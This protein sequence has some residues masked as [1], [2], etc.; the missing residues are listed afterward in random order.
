M[1]DFIQIF[2][3]MR[4]TIAFNWKGLKRFSNVD[5]WTYRL[6]VSAEFCSFMEKRLEG[7]LYWG[8]SL[9]TLRLISR[10]VQMRVKSRCIWVV[11]PVRPLWELRNEIL[12]LWQWNKGNILHMFCFAPKICRYDFFCLRFLFMTYTINLM[13]QFQSDICRLWLLLDYHLFTLF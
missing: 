11:V 2:S 5:R 13:F 7:L 1:D 10:R 4:R 8:F 12:Q 6:D 9:I 3:F